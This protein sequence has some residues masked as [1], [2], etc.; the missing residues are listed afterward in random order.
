MEEKS[1]SATVLANTMFY[2]WRGDYGAKKQHWFPSNY[3]EEI[4]AHS[5]SS[6]E[7]M[8]LGSLQQG[9]IDVQGCY[10]GK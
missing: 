5:D 7:S 1:K 4:E 6:S 3:V 8:P 9:S 2:R 10:V